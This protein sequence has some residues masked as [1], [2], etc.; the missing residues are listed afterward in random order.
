MEIGIMLDAPLFLGFGAAATNDLVEYERMQTNRSYC[1][2][3]G[4]TMGASLISA[5]TSSS[6]SNSSTS[7]SSR[8]KTR[9]NKLRGDSNSAD[10]STWCDYHAI[11][12]V[13]QK[14]DDEKYITKFSKF[15]S[16]EI[17][18]LSKTV[19]ENV[20]SNGKMNSTLHMELMLVGVLFTITLLV[21][22]NSL[23]RTCRRACATFT[24]SDTVRQ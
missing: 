16:S 6:G 23:A 20:D 21:C 3:R 13:R 12:T 8:R 4:G 22:G 1:V 11:E 19:E 7:S 17:D 10:P 2:T 9:E 15:V 18:A 24:K 14:R 5:T